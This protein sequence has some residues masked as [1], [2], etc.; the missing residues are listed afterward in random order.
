MPSPLRVYLLRF[1]NRAAF[2]EAFALVIDSEIVASCTAEPEQ[3]RIRFLAPA[4]RAD[5]LL[6][7]IYQRAGFSWC[8]R[9]DL[10]SQPLVAAD[11]KLRVDRREG[12][13][14]AAGDR[15]GD[16]RVPDQPRRA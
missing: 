4:R 15:A 9:H 12:G 10:V 3:A 11:A 8:S 1:A 2:S 5:A 14:R 6:H 13:C 16:P 7:E